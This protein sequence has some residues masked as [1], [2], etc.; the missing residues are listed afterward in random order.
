MVLQIVYVVIPTKA[1]KGRVEE[2]PPEAL[3]RELGEIRFSRKDRV[4]AVKKCLLR[5]NVPK[6][7]SAT[8]I[9]VAPHCGDHL[10]RLISALSIF[11]AG[12]AARSPLK[13]VHRTVFRAFR[14][15][16]RS[17][18]LRPPRASLGRNDRR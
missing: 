16:W 15:H 17:K 10:F 3:T 1:R 8:S 7:I 9:G 18:A 5:D 11:L 4:E 2:S 6:E 14:T 13:T 12:A